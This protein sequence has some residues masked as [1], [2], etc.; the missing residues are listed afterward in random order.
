M[1]INANIANW[2][3]GK[4]LMDNGSSADIMFANTFD[5]MELNRNLLQ[6]SDTPL[7]GFGGKVIH[8]LGKISLLV[9]FGAVQNVRI[10]HISFDVVEMYYPYFGIFGREFLNKFEAAIYQAYLCM[11]MP[12]LHGVI[13]IFGDQGDGRNLERGRTLGQRNVNALEVE[14]QAKKVL[15]EPKRDKEKVNIKENCDTKRL[16]LD[17][18]VFGQEVIIGTDLEP[19]EEKRLV[20][21]LCKNKDVFAWSANDLAG[22]NRNI[23]EHKMSIEKAIRP[24]R[25]KLRKMSNDKVTAVK[26]EVQ[27]LLNA[28]IIREV[29]YP[30]WLA[31][32]IPIKKKNGK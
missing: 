2:A 7:Y 17:D 11:K 14:S 8:A 32:T 20:E 21:L 13:T 27:R 18:M 15:E 3:L 4:I 1:V 25:Q 22:V 16:L 19:K 5:K 10:E 26:S 12:T 29:E 24:K 28:K 23:I 6:P 31:N 9:S 30:Q